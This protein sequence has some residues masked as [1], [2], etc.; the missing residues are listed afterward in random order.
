MC[1]RVRRLSHY[2]RKKRPGLRRAKGLVCARIWTD[3][4]AELG[5][6]EAPPK[7]ATASNRVYCNQLILYYADCLQVDQERLKNRTSTVIHPLHSL[8]F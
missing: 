3:H 8:V 2:W 7:G 1:H 4:T 6:D 5:K